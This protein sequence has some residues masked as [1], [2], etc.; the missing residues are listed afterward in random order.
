[1]TIGLQQ[2]TENTPHNFL[3]PSSKHVNWTNKLK[4]VLHPIVTI[5]KVPSINQFYE[6]LQDIIKAREEFHRHVLKEANGLV[7]VPWPNLNLLSVLVH[8]DFFTC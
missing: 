1:V 6:S 4:L 8:L 2:V 7:V 5:Q 3:G